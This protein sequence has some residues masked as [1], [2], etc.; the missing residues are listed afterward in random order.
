MIEKDKE[1]EKN[2]GLT[3]TKHIKQASQKFEF[4]RSLR[5]GEVVEDCS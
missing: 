2:S 4:N 5:E 1:E 3:F